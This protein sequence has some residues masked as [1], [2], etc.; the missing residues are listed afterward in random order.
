MCQYITNRM[1]KH[2]CAAPAGVNTAGARSRPLYTQMFKNNHPACTLPTWN[3]SDVAFWT[4]ASL[5]ATYSFHRKVKHTGTAAPR[6]TWHVWNTAVLSTFQNKMKTK[7]RRDAFSSHRHRET[8]RA[9]AASKINECL[10]MFLMS[11]I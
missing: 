8:Q 11:Y 4:S 9:R 1:L 6:H 2:D 5:D 3:C 10:T 7:N